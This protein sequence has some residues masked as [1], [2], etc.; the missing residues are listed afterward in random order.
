MPSPG[1]EP[2][3]EAWKRFHERYLASRLAES[4]ADISKAGESLALLY[5]PLRGLCMHHIIQRL[6]EAHPETASLPGQIAR[7]QACA[8]KS[9][10]F[11]LPG[12]SLGKWRS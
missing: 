4:A 8:S 6:L 9:D 12:G 5:V 1:A 3:G 10:D 2:Q 7:M 11:T